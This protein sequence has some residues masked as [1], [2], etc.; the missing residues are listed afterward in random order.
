MG[1]CVT[2]PGGRERGH[3]AVSTGHPGTS[4]TLEVPAGYWLRSSLGWSSSWAQCGP[5]KEGEAPRL[6]EQRGTRGPL[7][8]YMFSRAQGREMEV[9]FPKYRFCVSC[10]LSLRLDTEDLEFLRR[11]LPPFG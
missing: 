3:Q 9:T 7:R 6:R 4:Q 10:F 11:L 8:G 1:K 5:G 2:P